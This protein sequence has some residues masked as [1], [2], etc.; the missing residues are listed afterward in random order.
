VNPPKQ[1]RLSEV[2]ARELKARG[3]KERRLKGH[4]IATE[5]RHESGETAFSLHDA[6]VKQIMREIR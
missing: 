6:L 1:E 5:W 3:W 4:R 2:I